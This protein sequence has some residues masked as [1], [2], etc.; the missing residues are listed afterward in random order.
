MRLRDKATETNIVFQDISAIR[1][2]YKL[3]RHHC[4]LCKDKKYF[5]ITRYFGV[6]YCFFHRALGVGVH[7]CHELQYYIDIFNWE[8]KR[9]Q[10]SKDS[11]SNLVTISPINWLPPNAKGYSWGLIALKDIE[12]NTIIIQLDNVPFF[13]QNELKNSQLGSSCYTS[14]AYKGTRG[15]K[16]ITAW[17]TSF[18]EWILFSAVNSSFQSGK[19]ANAEFQQGYTEIENCA[20]ISITTTK[21]IAKGDEI[22]VHYI[23]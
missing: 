1:N 2:H 17:T 22:L 4:F 5:P 18:A 9:L 20:S 21:N 3:S 6:L 8:A 11:L 15:K 10:K 13:N 14:A 7:R 23:I 19:K 12:R 16:L